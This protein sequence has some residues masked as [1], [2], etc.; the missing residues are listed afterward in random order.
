[1]TAL[2]PVDPLD[3]PARMPPAWDH[4][5]RRKFHG[6]L[7][8][9]IKCFQQHA[10]REG[11]A[12]AVESSLNVVCESYT[13]PFDPTAFK[14]QAS[15][16]DASLKSDFLKATEVLSE[17]FGSRMPSLAWNV[18]A[19]MGTRD[20]PTTKQTIL[21]QSDALKQHYLHWTEADA[22]LHALGKVYGLMLH[23]QSRIYEHTGMLLE[24]SCDCNSDLYALESNGA[25]RV[26][27]QKR[28]HAEHTAA[29]LSHLLSEI[30]LIQHLKLPFEMGL[31]PDLERFAAA[32]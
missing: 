28:H 16:P 29:F 12:T 19:F 1:M 31:T 15:D 23:V 14:P 8:L 27:L 6:D 5:M 3:S 17:D 4:L 7:L 21:S 9:R 18:L 32:S 25:I 20:N 13:M 11:Y 2:S 24:H 30:T 22:V 10:E 26:L